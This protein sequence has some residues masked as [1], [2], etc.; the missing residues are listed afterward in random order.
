MRNE[1]RETVCGFLMYYLL[2]R[3]TDQELWKEI[4]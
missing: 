2:R 3:L 4:Y 1:K